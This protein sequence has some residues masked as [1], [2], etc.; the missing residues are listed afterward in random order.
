MP[1]SLTWT[2]TGG[3]VSVAGQFTSGTTPG[4]NYTV[5]ATSGSVSGSA[6][7]T[8][9]NA[10]PT[11]VNAAEASPSP[12]TTASTNLMVLGADDAGESNLT[13]T[14]SV[15]SKPGGSTT[16]TF[17]VNGANGAKST[18]VT[19][20]QAGTYTLLVTITDGSG[21]SV[22]SSVNVT[23][24]LA[25][26]S[27][28]V[29][30]SSPT[31]GENMSQQFSAVAYDQ[32]GNR[33]ASQPN[34]TWS[35][36][37][38]GDGGTITSSGLYTAPAT[39]GS[40]TIEAAF[41]SSIGGLATAH[42]IFI[43]QSLGIFTAAQDIG[44]PAIAGSSNYDTS[45][46]TY[47]VSG[48]GSDISGTSDQFQYIYT[49]VTGD[50]S[51]TAQVTS[52]TNTNGSA[53][54]GVM[55]RNAL[56]PD[57]TDMYLCVT[58]TGGIKLEGRTSDGGTATIDDTATGLTAPYWIRLIRT[59]NLF[60]AFISPDG[61]TWTNLG[62][63]TVAMNTTVY[64]GLAV[65]SHNTAA[66][67]N[68]TFQNVS[69][70]TPATI[71]SAVSR[72]PQGATNFDLSLA[73][74][75]TPTIE[76]RLGGPTQIILT[77]AQALDNTQPLSL[78][79]SSGTGQAVFS[80]TSPS[81]IIVTL[82]GAT[83]GQV[84]TLSVAGVAAAGGP[85][86]MYSLSISVLAGDVDQSGSV[87]VADISYV[88]LN[89]GFPVTSSNFLD[90][91]TAD[92][93]INVA[94]VS[95][96]KLRSGNL[97]STGGTNSGPVEAVPLATEQLESATLTAA[98]TQPQIDAAPTAAIQGTELDSLAPVILPS[99]DVL[100]AITIAAA[101][102][103]P[104]GT[105]DSRSNAIA[106]PGLASSE[107]S[108]VPGASVESA[109]FSVHISQPMDA[110]APSRAKSVRSEISTGQIEAT[111]TSQFHDFLLASEDFRLDF[112]IGH[113]KKFARRGKRSWGD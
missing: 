98:T 39:A 56:T 17:A 3:T 113:H 49:P 94:D 32:F 76:P 53:K 26:N 52:I 55:F 72:K 15:T 69:I 91:V 109:S 2:A 88:K 35:V 60:T 51:I 112:Q 104:A 102:P 28:V 6:T 41:N 92:G 105:S 30:P 103:D 101:P 67:N 25:T 57:S 33:M 68:S 64:V 23:V 70:V 42:V 73:L 31:V 66:L 48:A 47:S 46:S 19:F 85:P 107:N 54:S 100:P 14:W 29:T 10:A 89:S 84:L 93:A 21:A 90:D 81:Q 110:V 83:D 65:T 59:G 87:N 108:S 62:S 106:G 24:N 82:S 22:T 75:G 74:S 36:L 4:S 111:S 63:V 18:I 11:I 71:T 1:V 44:S 97:L 34:F 95:S 7:I 79:L 43:A 13:Y 86:E 80:Q 38:G 12:V 8:V 40:D 58:P 77:F 16:P 20:F 27:V 99:N 61:N 96:V 9:T 78:T 50:A 37:N 5:T 45:T